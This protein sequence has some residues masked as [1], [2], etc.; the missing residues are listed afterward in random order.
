ML[1]GFLLG[2]LG[3]PPVVAAIVVIVA[4]MFGPHLYSH[5]WLPYQLRAGLRRLVDPTAGP[6][7]SAGPVEDGFP[8]RADGRGRERLA[9]ARPTGWPTTS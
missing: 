4:L 3:V 5:Y 9:L 8:R 6:P 2:A 7:V 1:F